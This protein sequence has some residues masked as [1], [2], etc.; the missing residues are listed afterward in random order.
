MKRVPRA[1]NRA[2]ISPLWVKD[3]MF[4]AEKQSPPVAIFI[5]TCGIW[6][7]RLFLTKNEKQALK[8]DYI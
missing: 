1:K 2:F 6:F 8:L 4:A 3:I 5:A 7:F